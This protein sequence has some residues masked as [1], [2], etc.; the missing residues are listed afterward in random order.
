MLPEGDYL[1]S[2]K[3]ME[4]GERTGPTS[5]TALLTH[6]IPA[7]P[8]LLTPAEG[9]VVPLSGV[10]MSWAPVTQTLTGDDVTIIAYQLIVEQDAEPDAH[11]IGTFG[12]SMYVAPSVTSITLPDGFLEPGTRYQWE[13]LAIE[14]SGNQTLSSSEFA[15]E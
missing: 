2:G 1:I 7:G 6:A 12:L 13:V 15:T 4:A 3:G 14:A 10:T 9:S 11:M 5:G 8:E